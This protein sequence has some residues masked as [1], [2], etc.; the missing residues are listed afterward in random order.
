M[1]RT[2]SADSK[3]VLFVLVRMLPRA[4][5]FQ[6]GLRFADLSWCDGDLN[7]ESLKQFEDAAKIRVDLASKG[8][9]EAVPS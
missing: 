2:R 6:Q 5:Q 3:A 7:F 9:I 4:T 1:F 8:L